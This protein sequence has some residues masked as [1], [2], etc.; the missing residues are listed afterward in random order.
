[1]LGLA[2]YTGLFASFSGAGYPFLAEN[3]A[4]SARMRIFSIHASLVLASQVLGMGGGFLADAL[5]AV[6]MN[7]VGLKTALFI[8]GLATLAAFIPLLFTADQKAEDIQALDA[9]LPDHQPAQAGRA[10]NAS[11]LGITKSSGSSRLPIINRP[12]LRACRALFEFVL[13]QPL[14]GIV[15]GSRHSDITRTSHD[16]CIDADRTNAGKSGGSRQGRCA[17]SSPILAL[18]AVNRVHERT[19]HC[20]GRLP[21]PPSLDECRQSDTILDSD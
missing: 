21:V 14:L 6:G 13:Y 18:P 8:G 16:D 2:V 19:P 11:G 4:K 12:G 10:V 1:M 3:T 17:L 15:I 7:K 20:I 5:Q 9:P